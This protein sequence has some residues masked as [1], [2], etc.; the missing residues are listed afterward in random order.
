M[1]ENLG[2]MLAEVLGGLEGLFARHELV[3]HPDLVVLLFHYLQVIDPA[4]DT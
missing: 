3:P 4:C 1:D 2:F